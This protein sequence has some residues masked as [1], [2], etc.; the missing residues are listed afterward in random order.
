MRDRCKFRRLERLLGCLIFVPGSDLVLRKED[1]GA[2]QRSL[3]GLGVEAH[4]AAAGQGVNMNG[5]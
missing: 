1:S 2:I 3:G 5:R 4:A